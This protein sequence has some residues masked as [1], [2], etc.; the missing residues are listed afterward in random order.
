MP[1]KKKYHLPKHCNFIRMKRIITFATLLLFLTCTAISYA[2]EFGGNPAS[3][4]WKQI[5]NRKTKIIFPNGMDSQANRI[6]NINILLA[7]NTAY[8]IGGKQRKWNI[9]LLNQTTISNAY[10]RMAPIMSELYMIPGQN[11]F[12][13][14]SLRWDDNLIIHE[15]RH[16]QQFSNF[17]NGLTK[18][19]SFVLGQ[20]GQL[21]AN[22]I[23]I[24]DY[25]FEGDAVWQETLVSAQGRGRMPAFFNGMKSLA[26]GNKKYPWMKLRSGSL[27]HYTPDHYELGYQLVAYGYEKYGEDFWRKVTNDAVHFKGLFFAFNKAIERY[28]GKSYQQFREDAIQYFIERSIPDNEKHNAGFQLITAAKKNNV[29]DYLFAQYSGDDSIIVT[30]Q[31]FK[32]INSFYVLANGKEEKIRV[33]NY[34]T[35]EY[36]SYRNGKIVYASYQSDPRWGNRNYSVVQLVNIH[37]RQQKQLTFK[38][39]YFSPDINK[40]GSEVLAV[41]VN[42]DGTNFLHRLNAETG[43]LT[44]ELPNPHNY[45][46]TQVKYIDN[47]TAIAAVRNAEGKM[48]LVKVD[49]NDGETESV[50]PFSFNVVGNPFVKGDTVYFGAMNKNADKI[51]AVNLGDKKIYQ[52]TGNVNGMYQPAVNSKDE[53]LVT[54]FT[55]DGSGLAK[56]PPTN[57]KWQQVTDEG[58]TTTPD[59]YTPAALRKKGEGLLY[60]VRDTISK[61]TAY[62]KGFH[63]FNFHSWR[64]EVSDPEYSYNFYSDNILSSF[65]QTARYTYNRSDRSS[66]IGLYETFAGWL[67]VLSLGNEY[68][69]NRRFYDTSGRAVPY[70]S[71]KLNATVYVP[72]SFVGGRTATNL[73]FGAGYNIEKIYF[74]GI[75]KTRFKADPLKYYNLFL[76]F[77]HS[78]RMARQ[79]INPHWAQSLSLS[80]RNAFEAIKT[81]KFVIN[82]SFYFPGLFTNHSFVLNASF[83]KRDTTSSYFSNNFSYSRGYE[84]LNTRQMYKLGANYHFPV[85]YPD[86]GFG[87]MI[88]F[89]RVRANAFYDYTIARARVNGI[90]TDLK[91]RSAG[92]EIYFDTKV[93]NALPVSFGF[94]YSRLLDKDLNNPGGK[95]IFEFIVPIG[96]IPD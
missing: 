9:V 58:F 95:N 17:N 90:L 65:S 18:V 28:S 32:E 56:A 24:P 71:G 66:T 25:F 54:A 96:L 3:L 5:N 51:F 8:S 62:K 89:Q 26:L 63:L 14:G 47:Y 94:R 83:Q 75:D 29:V 72:L 85:I 13:N 91:N 76:S 4:K 57:T 81:D 86:W 70:K 61:I 46:Y 53:L 79:H 42:T 16:I 31:S 30:K 93:W 27:K 20:E 67:P 40:D 88:F 44:A 10:V 48:C 2:Q 73:N 33:K 15:N 84:A 55:A 6:N 87:N 52:L 22:G 77:S 60:T 64:P 39:K 80:Y 41:N 36:F 92:T 34:V 35:D 69:F 37:T 11:N 21:L 45:F 23:A 82:S 7:N 78:S 19:F 74:T 38:S 68:S 59:L 49:L 43:L 12:S 1:L 50:T